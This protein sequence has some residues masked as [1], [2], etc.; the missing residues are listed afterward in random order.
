MPG[1]AADERFAGLP[2]RVT[3]PQ[4]A[5]MGSQSYLACLRRTA[6]SHHAGMA[7]F[8][9]IPAGAA[10]PDALHQADDRHFHQM[11]RLDAG[12]VLNTRAV[13]GLYRYMLP[14]NSSG[15][16]DDPPLGNFYFDCR[17]RA[18]MAA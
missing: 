15:I 11:A 13:S 5:M 2:P 6:R 10:R 16:A 12:R 14:R 4:I 7:A 9:A 17:R 3:A 8:G 1:D 18:A